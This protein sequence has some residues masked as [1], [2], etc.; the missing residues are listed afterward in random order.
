MIKV[1]VVEDS[2]S[3][4]MAIKKTLNLAFNEITIVSA[5][6]YSEAEN[7]LQ[8]N[9]ADDFL[10]AVL[11]INLPDAADGEV[12][13]LVNSY[14]IPA[15]VLTA[16]YT[17]ELQEFVWTKKIVDYVV[18]EGVHSLQFVSKQINRFKKNKSTK[19]MVVDDSRVARK[20]IISLLVTQKF[21][22]IEATD[23]RNALALLAEHSDIK[24]IITDYNMP[25]MDGF[26]LTKEV[27]KQYDPETIAIIGISSSESNKLSVRFIKN[28]AND[29]ITKPFLSEQFYCRL[30]QNLEIIDH[31]DALKKAAETDFLTNVYNRRYFFNIGK[32]LFNNAARNKSV[33]AVAM[34]DIDHFKKINDEYG[35]ETGDFVLKSMADLLKNYFRKTDIV[36]RFGGEE[37][38]IVA[39]NTNSENVF[40]LFDKLRLKIEESEMVYNDNNIKYT[41]SIGV[42]LEKLNSLEDMVRDADK[43][44]YNA[45]SGGRNRVIS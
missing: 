4:M 16:T 9:H 45:K 29:F 37:F 6:S 13:D 31:V 43:Q 14:K 12:I 32:M 26:E 19:I 28:G 18:K 15:I 38:C 25:E 40:H 33:L 7:I 20:H 17:D 27:R 11:D 10:I 30:Y 36:A 39:T 44:L 34:I 24:M 5:Y 8:N 22:V 1:L 35:H 23:G 3:Y 41:V 21:I 2:K 42:S